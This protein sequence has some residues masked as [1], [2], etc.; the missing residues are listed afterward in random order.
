MT[1]LLTLLGQD[2]HL[3][4]QAGTDGGEYA[5]P[6]PFCGGEDRFRVWPNPPDGKPHYWCRQCG[7]H[8]DAIDYLRDKHG[9]SYREACDRLG[10]EPTVWSAPPA[11]APKHP[12]GC[13]PPGPDWQEQARQFVTEC[14]ANLWA[15]DGADALAWLT[16]RRG[17]TS[18]TVRAA[19]LGYNPT[20]RHDSRDVWGLETDGKPVWLPRGVVI[21]WT[22][23]DDVWRVNIRRPTGEPKYIGPA[24]CG[25]GLYG[26]DALVTARPA[27][28]LE[29]ELNA[30]TIRQHAGDL[31]APV[32][33]GSTHG[34]RRSRWLARL[35]L[36]SEVLVTFDADKAGDDASAYWLGTLSNARRWRPLWADTNDMATDG[37]DVRGWVAA[38]VPGTW[39][40]CNACG[41][42]TPPNRPYCPRC[43]EA[44]RNE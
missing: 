40:R 22:I 18:E 13:D 39:R 29:G 27:M 33:T 30:L 14:Q 34:A 32:A 9:L 35:A 25:P 21:P 12:E 15:P 38:A 19:G 4:R 11:L 3:R 7:H 23:G 10:I 28:L 43:V 44:A 6:C 37:A 17:L 5:G 20:D 16:D 26:A 42:P 31:V 1:D 41:G 36:A 8:G 24:G 2:T